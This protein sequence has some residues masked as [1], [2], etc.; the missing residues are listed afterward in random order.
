[1]LK[2]ISL[3]AGDIMEDMI[4]IAECFGIE[5]MC[6]YKTRYYYTARCGRTE[7]RILPTV[8]S[9]DK[10]KNVY[11]IKESLFERK[12][13]LCDRLVPSVDGNI[14]VE[15]DES[16]YIMTEAVRGHSLEFENAAE[17]RA[18]FAA[19]GSLH[20]ALR[21]VKCEREDILK[22]YS[23]GVLRLKAVK[24]QLG[25]AKKLNDT[26]KEFLRHY[27]DYYNMAKNA[28]E[29]MEGLY[30]GVTCP[31]HGTVKEDNIY[32]GRNI[33]FTD[34]ELTRSGH[35]MEDVAQLISRYI[36]KYACYTADHLT[37]DEILD[38]YTAENPVSDNELAVLYAL[39]MYPKRYI[40][41]T[42]KYYGKAHKFTPVGIRKKFEECYKNKAFFMEYIGVK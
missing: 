9:E 38:S 24:K 3:I 2:T 13:K 31:I 20:K 7:Y 41:M 17:L 12:L 15:G 32:I 8:M 18:A 11:N 42:A 14:S 6:V 30:F 21:S 40:A 26:D 25:C 10:L 27:P 33:T 39:L 37:L 16:R 34:W 28:C 22:S 36:R 35:F 1:M 4:K 5:P 19:L 29:V 23:K